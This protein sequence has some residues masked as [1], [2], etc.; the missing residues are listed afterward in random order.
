MKFDAPVQMVTEPATPVPYQEDLPDWRAGRFTSVDSLVWAYSYFYRH[1]DSR[2]SQ[3]VDYREWTEALRVDAPPRAYVPSQIE[4]RQARDA[5]GRFL[6]RAIPAKPDRDLLFY[7]IFYPIP[8]LGLQ[9]V[10][11]V[12]D[13]FDRSREWAHAHFGRLNDRVYRALRRRGYRID[14]Q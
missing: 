4:A 6:L 11:D 3:A 2:T 12:A 1:S 9:R 8:S 13:L 7:M 10:G 5:I 14:L